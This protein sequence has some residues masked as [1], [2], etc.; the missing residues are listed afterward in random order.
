MFPINTTLSSWEFQ[1]MTGLLCLAIVSKLQLNGCGLLEGFQGM[2]ICESK[3]K[4]FGRKDMFFSCFIFLW[5]NFSF[6]FCRS[7]TF[8]QLLSLAVNLAKWEEQAKFSL[9]ICTFK[10]A[11][12]FSSAVLGMNPGVLSSCVW[13]FF[14]LRVWAEFRRLALLTVTSNLSLEEV[15]TGRGRFGYLMAFYFYQLAFYT[16]PV[17]NSLICVWRAKTFSLFG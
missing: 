1:S 12:S 2:V 13:T 7:H 11:N 17:A 8:A 15:Y 10:Q 3:G 14:R 4:P 16:C 9:V 6:F 5:W